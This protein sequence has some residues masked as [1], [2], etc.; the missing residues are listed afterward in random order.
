M[1]GILNILLLRDV[2]DC[3]V[4]VAR[5]AFRFGFVGVLVCFGLIVRFV[6]L[7]AV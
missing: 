7:A 2:N 1:F 5:L 4:S 6:V 3:L